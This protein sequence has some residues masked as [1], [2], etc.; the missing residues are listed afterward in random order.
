MIY[1]NKID[2][3]YCIVFFNNN[4][5]NAKKYIKI[6]NKKILRPMIRTTSILKIRTR[7]RLILRTI[8]RLIKIFELIICRP[9][10]TP[11]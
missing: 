5:I 7:S 9:K 6:N 1:T 8:L 11:S 2:S 4:E 10:N 3:K